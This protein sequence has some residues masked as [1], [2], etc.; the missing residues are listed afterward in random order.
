M[1][2][3]IFN[4]MIHLISLD[5]LRKVL[6]PIW[7]GYYAILVDKTRDIANI[8]QLVT[9][10][11]WVDDTYT[12]REDFLGLFDLPKTDAH[13]IFTVLNDILRRC[14]ILPELCRGH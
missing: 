10:L 1:C 13:T 12:V 4:G 11:R 5:V 14:N 6:S 8:E 9:V 3:D 2:H 7:D